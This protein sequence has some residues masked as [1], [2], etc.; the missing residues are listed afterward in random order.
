[1]SHP[2][3]RSF[4]ERVQDVANI[5]RSVSLQ[6]HKRLA[7]SDNVVKGIGASV[8]S[9]ELRGDLFGSIQSLNVELV[10]LS[11]LADLFPEAELA[12]ARPVLICLIPLAETVE[13]VIG[14]DGLLNEMEQ[15]RWSRLRH[16][17]SLQAEIITKHADDVLSEMPEAAPLPEPSERFRSLVGETDPY[18][19]SGLDPVD[20]AVLRAFKEKG[21]SASE[22]LA[23]SAEQ[24]RNI[25]FWALYE[26]DGMKDAAIRDHWYKIGGKPMLTK[27]SKTA[28]ADVAK[29]CRQRGGDLLDN[30]R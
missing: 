5:T 4:C 14:Q 2:T 25:A 18:S 28:A 23:I 10:Q 19:T 20:A 8:G 16:L 26:L 30:L 22:R 24:R 17:L 15:E 9:A 1:M 7:A 11:D 21:V 27:S 13:Y 12:A 6:I 29:S 3:V